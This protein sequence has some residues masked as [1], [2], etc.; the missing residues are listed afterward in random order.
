VCGQD[1]ADIVLGNCHGAA[2]A[3]QILEAARRFLAARGFAV[4]I[5]SPYAGGFTPGHY[6]CP[7][8][9]RHALPIETNP[10]LY[11]NERELCRKPNFA[12]LVRALAELVERLGRAVSECLAEPARA[13]L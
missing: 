6:G 8:G 7:S 11:I 3:P 12:R 9:Q 13:A 5:N 2:C 4:A 10:G 1:G